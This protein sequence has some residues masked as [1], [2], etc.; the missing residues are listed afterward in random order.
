MTPQIS[1]SKYK[2]SELSFLDFGHFFREPKFRRL[3]RRKEV[4]RKSKQIGNS[5]LEDRPIGILGSGAAECADLA[6]ALEL[7]NSTISVKHASSLGR[8]I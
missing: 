8:R 6:Q 3:V 4:D 2:R 5:R 7:A 1:N